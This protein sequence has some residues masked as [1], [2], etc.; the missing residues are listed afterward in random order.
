MNPQAGLQKMQFN[1]VNFAMKIKVC[2]SKKIPSITH[3][4]F[5]RACKWVRAAKA[6]GN[7]HGWWNKAKEIKTKLR[8][9]PQYV[10]L[11]GLCWGALQVHTIIFSCS[12]CS[13]CGIFL[14][15]SVATRSVPRQL[16]TVIRLFISLSHYF[17]VQ[18][19][20]DSQLDSVIFPTLIPL[21]LV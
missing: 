9:C 11:M 1:S 8:Y 17:V 7:M 20:T 14:F 6:A 21:S 2:N 15:Y 10:F 4:K 18:R 13:F 5:I 3:N 19:W 16:Y 12:C